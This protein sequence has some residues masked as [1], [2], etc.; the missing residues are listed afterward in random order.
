VSNK[1]NDFASEISAML[2]HAQ[3]IGFRA[4]DIQSG[5]VHR[6]IGGYPGTNHR[7]PVCCEAMR[8]A[9]KPGDEIVKQPPK[10]SGASLVVRYQLPR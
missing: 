9:M 5:A 6:K 1:A 2:G 3:R 10:G 4:V 8:A 7:M